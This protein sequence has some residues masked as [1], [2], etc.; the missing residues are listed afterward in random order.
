M[1]EWVHV[2]EALDDA[3]V[4]NELKDHILEWYRNIHYDFTIQD[5]TET[6]IASRG[7]K[8]GCLVA[9]LIWSLVTGRLLYRLALATDVRWVSQQVTAYADDFHA[10]ATAHNYQDL[11][12]AERFFSQ[13][14]DLL[15]QSGMIINASKSAI[16]YR[17]KGGFAKR[18]L[19]Q[20]IVQG[21]DGPLFR[22]RTDAG[23]LFEFPVVDSHTYLG[24]KISYTDPQ[25][26]TLVYRMGL[27]KLEWSRLR[28]LV[29]SRHGLFRQDR[30]R[31]WFSSVPPTLLYGLAATGLP[32][33]GGRQLRNLYM[34]HLRAILR[35]P[36][37][38]SH[39]SNREVLARAKVPDICATLEK[40]MHRLAHNV[41]R[42]AQ[43]ESFM[44]SSQLQGHMNFVCNSLRE[45][46]LMADQASSSY[47]NSADSEAVFDCRYCGR[48]FATH[49]LRRSHESKIHNSRTPQPLPDAQLFDRWQHGLDGMPTC[50]HCGHQF[51]K[52]HNLQKHIVKQ[53]C[54]ALRVSTQSMALATHPQM[55]SHGPS[56]NDSQ[57]P[58]DAISV[59][60]P[61][62]QEEVLPIIRRPSIRSILLQ[63]GWH[64]LLHCQEL[65]RELEH[66]CPFCRQWCM[67]QA[68]IKRHMT[69]QHAEWV[70]NFAN[71]MPHLTPFRRH[72]VIP[73][74][75]C[76][77]QAVNKHTHWRN[78]LIVQV[79]CF[80]G[81]S[82]KVPATTHGAHGAVGS[83]EELLRWNM[84]ITRAFDDQEGER[85]G[86]TRD[87]EGPAGGSCSTVGQVE[88]TQ[89]QREGQGQR[90]RQGKGGTDLMAYFR[91][92]DAS[93]GSARSSMGRILGTGHGSPRS[94]SH[95]TAPKSA[96][97]APRICIGE[98]SP[99]YQHVLVCQA[100]GRNVDPN[101]VL[102]VRKMESDPA[103]EPTTHR[104][105]TQDCVDES[106]PH[107]AMQS[108]DQ[109]CQERGNDA[110]GQGH[111]LA[112]RSWGVE[113]SQV[114]SS[115]GEAARGAGCTHQADGTSDLGSQRTSE[116]HQCRES[117]QVPIG[118]WASQGSSDLLGKAGDRSV[119]SEPRRTSLG[120]PT[121]V[122]WLGGSAYHGVSTPKGERGP[123]LPG[124]DAS[125][126]TAGPLPSA[127]T[128]LH[129][130]LPQNVSPTH[131][132]R[133]TPVEFPIMIQD[134][135]AGVQAVMQCLLWPFWC[136]AQRQHLTLGM[137]HQLWVQSMQQSHAIVH[138]NRK[139]Q[140]NAVVRKLQN[141]P[142]PALDAILKLFLTS[143]KS[144]AHS[145][146]WGTH[147]SAVDEV[148]AHAKI[149]DSC[150]C[151]QINM[152]P[153][154]NT[155]QECVDAW[156]ATPSRLCLLRPAETIFLVLKH[157][158]RGL[159]AGGPQLFT[160]L[161]A[162]IALP[163][164][165][166]NT[167]DTFL[168]HYQVRSI[169]ACEAAA[170]AAGVYRTMHRCK[171]EDHGN[172]LHA[173][174]ST[175]PSATSV[176]L[177]ALR[178]CECQESDS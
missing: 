160:D 68:A 90:Q 133:H 156:G 116:D 171:R 74:R 34:R 158:R 111:G 108:A 70:Q 36:A 73:C 12:T 178:K 173:F 76:H 170:S 104:L 24:T 46:C 91:R 103:R 67:D 138:L 132:D 136:D 165:A 125:L 105:V 4:P 113:D 144:D 146:E 19:R 33:A 87:E 5:H 9:P 95:G 157:C 110:G 121:G 102:C 32:K 126:V 147:P 3:G 71:L 77:S 31:I 152:P 114:G 154:Y 37:H 92:V 159:D 162:D 142:K 55:A 174:T 94:P 131:P 45:G 49:R 65:K 59:G 15:V 44:V 79:S 28:K 29:C 14:L 117:I 17:F 16:L 140:W 27:A 2:A 75:Y 41:H 13:F 118:I 89:G 155:L 122:D 7:L 176:L 141:M 101:P 161:E 168:V 21:P 163:V 78:C 8:Q 88:S 135:P 11:Q 177:I 112:D 120:H 119:A 18:W 66:H 82:S 151:L 64:A 106:L 84:P 150:M 80:L 63:S 52:W 72:M 149:P 115:S 60:M 148:G 107:R 129:P 169:V 123:V 56:H 23:R 124:T 93:R 1:L 61:V 50:K 69:Q 153:A 100:G 26:Q 127:Q 139:L 30:L 109:H 98:P 175:H 143:H 167:S 128:R 10:A 51:R 35:C 137:Y 53:Q 86:L 85:R 39:V 42:L 164:A 54:H 134:I 58:Q 166:Q 38:I 20:H 99:G 43:Q 22:L 40:E 97:A 6:V 130:R 47:H 25:L 172:T 145:G 96:D 57:P 81:L 62:T 48:F 83:R